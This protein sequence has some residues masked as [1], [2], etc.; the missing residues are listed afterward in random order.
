MNNLSAE[1]VLKVWEQGLSRPLLD[2]SLMLLA[3]AFPETGPDALAE[4]TIGSRDVCLL[5]LRERLFGSKLV[6]NAVCPHCGERIEWEQDI[7]EL[8][9][10]SADVSAAGRFT[11]QQDGYDL[12]FRLPNSKDMAGLQGITQAEEAQKHLLDSLIISAE[13]AGQACEPG[14]IPEPVVRA[15]NER[16]EA[17]DPQAEIRIQLTCPECSKQWDVFFDIAG[18]L[19]TEIND[20]AERML[21]SVH[22]LARAYGWPERD[23]LN[24]SPIRRQLYLGMVGP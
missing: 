7:A 18:F 17:L 13:Y 9:A 15:L 12:C 19:W 2:R 23:I 5:L 11:L 3:A 20:W 4:L 8:V 14:Q 10:G 6:N 1:A 16:I 22:K 24:L 21:Q